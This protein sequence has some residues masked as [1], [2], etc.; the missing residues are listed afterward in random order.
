MAEAVRQ[1]SVQDLVALWGVKRQTVRRYIVSGR[2]KAHQHAALQPFYVADA[3]RL[4][5]E[6][7]VR[8]F[9]KPGRPRKKTA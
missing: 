3:E 8:P 4:R 7:E 1:W 6:N 9:L 2:L 5:F